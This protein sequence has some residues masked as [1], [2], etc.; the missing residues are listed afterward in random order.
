MEMTLS[1]DS[2]CRDVLSDIP[3]F[4]EFLQYLATQNAELGK[5]YNL[6]DIKTFIRI[7]GDYSD[8][9]TTGYAD[10]AFAAKIRDEI[11]EKYKRQPQN[12]ANTPFEVNVGFLLEH[13]STPD[14]NVMKQM[15]RYHY[16]LMYKRMQKNFRNGIPS[17]AIILYNGKDKW[18]PLKDITRIPPELRPLSLP[19][20]C[21]MLDVK[22][23]PD[24]TCE[25]FSVRLAAFISALK[26]VRNPEQNREFFKRIIKRIHKEL[27]QIGRLDLLH[28]LD[29]YL[30]GWVSTNFKEVFEMDFV[31]PPYKTIRDSYIEEG[32]AK[33]LLQGIEQERK[34]SAKII[35]KLQ[36]KIKKLQ[37]KL[38]E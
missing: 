32:I 10:L 11:L 18:N 17:I 16:H 26:Y 25:K 9:A 29:V 14:N 15:I 12:I 8:T 19:F 33:G 24:E 4:L 36:A 31:R 21:L 27:P 22:D 28:S 5:I 1:H 13:K 34:Q 3:T 30:D 35:A 23:I 2:F 38:G 7:P 37:A 6:L 20:K